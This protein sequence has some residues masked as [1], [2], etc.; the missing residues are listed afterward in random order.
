MENDWWLSKAH[1]IQGYADTNNLQAFYYAIK[2][3]YGP[4]KHRITPI[5][6]TDGTILHKDK[7]GILEHWAENFNTLLNQNNPTDPAFLQRLPKLPSAHELDDPPRF[8]EVLAA[9]RSLKDNK[10]AGPEIPTEALKNGGY[11]LTKNLHQLIQIIWAQ[12]TF[13][14][15]W[16]YS[17]ICIIHK[18]KGDKSIC[19][20]S[21]GISL[22]SVAG[23]AL[24]RVI[25]VR[26][27]HSVASGKIGPPPT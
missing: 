5:R 22:L 11:L 2:P 15:D 27:S 12:K 21:C 24:A 16:K 25:L 4:Q 1:E 20:N 3:L 8:S 26:L 10:S 9:V 7:Q 23:K 13:P 14:Q 6:S 19:G 17:N 18:K